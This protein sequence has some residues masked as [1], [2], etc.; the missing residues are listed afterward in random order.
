MKL[1]LFLLWAI[2]LHAF[3]TQPVTIATEI[4]CNEHIGPELFHSPDLFFRCK[5]NNNTIFHES[6]LTD[7]NA[8]PYVMGD[9][10]VFPGKE[11]WEYLKKKRRPEEDRSR[12][13]I[14]L[15]PNN[16]TEVTESFPVTLCLVLQD[17]K[18]A[19]F[20]SVLKQYG[21]STEVDFSFGFTDSNGAELSASGGIILSFGTDYLCMAKPGQTVQLISSPTFYVFANARYRVLKVEKDGI[22]YGDWQDAP[23]TKI[24]SKIPLLRCVTDPQDL[25][26]GLLF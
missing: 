8:R 2:P 11:P 3:L 1:F 17:E 23:D 15:E 7:H 4:N 5:D 19:I 10:R 6:R 9:L 26:C 24:H 18:G 21:V 16:Y 22:E 13:W 25:Q 20:G 12:N 14:E